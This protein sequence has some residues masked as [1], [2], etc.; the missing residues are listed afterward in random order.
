VLFR[1][2]Q[3]KDFAGS[4]NRIEKNRLIA[5][6][7]LGSIRKD[8]RITRMA[9]DLKQKKATKVVPEHYLSV[10]LPCSTRGYFFQQM[11]SHHS[12]QCS[13]LKF[14]VFRPSLAEH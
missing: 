3:D 7:P 13:V 4:R 1:P 8:P 2:E 9:T 14:S 6:N 11:E 10:F 5:P 12:S